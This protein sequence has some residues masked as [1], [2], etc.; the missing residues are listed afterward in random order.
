MSSPPI[1]AAVR[2]ATADD[3]A[4]IV[5]FSGGLG[6]WA[7]AQ[8]VA[9]QHGTGRLVLL[10]ADTLVEEPSLLR[11]LDQ[12]A[13]Q[14][15][16]SVTR[17]ADGRT[18]F[19]TYWDSKFLGNSRIA[20]CSRLLKQIPCRRWLDENVD[21]VSTVLYVGIDATERHRIP[22]IVKGWSP[23]TV[24]FPL[25]NEP[26]LTKQGMYDAAVALG[27][28]P[29]DAYREGFSHANCSGTCVRAG[30]RHWLHLLRVHPDRFAHYEAEEQRFRARYGNVAILKETRGGV[31][32][33]LPLAELR[34]R[35]DNP[36]A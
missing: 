9:A 20:P 14:L 33:P 24:D 15:G 28:T 3:P 4:R 1:C 18:P 31:T 12:A 10:W 26:A 32:R 13:H 22:G 16:V 11:F 36:A 6:S 25:A 19:Q 35:H 7:V 27:L 17:V 29:P 5:Q 30:Q 21:P 34:Q 2:G 23:W 8:R